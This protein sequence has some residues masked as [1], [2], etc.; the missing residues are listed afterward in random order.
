MAMLR[1]GAIVFLLAG[2]SMEKTNA[3]GE[4]AITQDMIPVTIEGHAMNVARYEVSMADWHACHADGGCSLDAFATAG[5]INLPMTGANW[6]DAMEFVSWSRERQRQEVRLPTLAE[7]RYLARAMHKQKPPPL[8]TDERLAWAANYG[9]EKTPTGP[10]HPRGSYS[11]SPDGI[12]DLD[13]N[14]WEWTST[15]ANNSAADRCPA[16]IAGGAHEA[17][18]S[19]FVREPATGGCALGSPPTHLGLRLVSD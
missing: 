5:A 3:P 6:F 7:W 10:P 11:T 14:V 1:L 19:V 9:Q 17:P 18:V 16:Y 13:G 8:F 2:L 12:S 4:R 15:C